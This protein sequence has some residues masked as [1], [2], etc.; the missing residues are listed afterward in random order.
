MHIKVL[1]INQTEKIEIIEFI[2]FPWCTLDPFTPDNPYGLLFQ[3][4]DFSLAPL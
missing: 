1:I 3:K 2:K 4:V